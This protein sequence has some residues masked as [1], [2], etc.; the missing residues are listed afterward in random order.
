MFS[1][2]PP[3]SLWNDGGFSFFGVSVLVLRHA[4]RRS[5]VRV[6]ALRQLSCARAW[7]ERWSNARI[8]SMFDS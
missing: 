8:A 3:F 5:A 4:V 7:H 1:T 6:A 2:T